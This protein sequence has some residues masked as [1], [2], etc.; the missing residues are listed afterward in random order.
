MEGLHPE[1]NAQYSPGNPTVLK[2]RHRKNIGWGLRK[3]KEG[4]KP[5]EYS[6][7]E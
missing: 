4:G 7:T 5:R 1:K 2:D 6:V 3:N